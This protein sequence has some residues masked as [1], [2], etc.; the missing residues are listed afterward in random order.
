MT[1]LGEEESARLEPIEESSLSLLESSLSCLLRGDRSASCS[2]MARR[3]LSKQRQVWWCAL[4]KTINKAWLGKEEVWLH[5][6]AGMRQLYSDL[7]YIN[8]Q[9]SR[10]GQLLLLSLDSRGVAVSSKHYILVVSF[11]AEQFTLTSY[12]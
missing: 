12:F 4:L 11:T 6:C 7:G 5:R 2:V 1:S 9:P 3:H 8:Q 10:E